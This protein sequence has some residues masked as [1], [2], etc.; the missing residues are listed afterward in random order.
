MLGSVLSDIAICHALFLTS[1]YLYPHSATLKMVASG[2][3]ETVVLTYQ[4]TWCHIPED[5]KLNTRWHGNLYITMCTLLAA[6]LSIYSAKHKDLLILW[7][8][9]QYTLTSTSI[10]IH[11]IIM[12]SIL[13]DGNKRELLSYGVPIFMYNNVLIK[14]KNAQ[15]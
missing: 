6:V 7:L 12:A 5:S 3:P 10:S 4:P 11:Q 14:L 15:K 9:M 2:F 13:T 1:L 8:S